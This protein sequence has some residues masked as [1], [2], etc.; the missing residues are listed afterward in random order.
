MRLLIVFLF[1]LSCLVA[2]AQH[3][4]DDLKYLKQ[5]PPALTPTVFAPGLISMSDEYEFGSVFNKDA[6]AF[7][8]AV[9]AEGGAEIRYSALRDDKWSEPVTI[10]SH[11]A[12]GFND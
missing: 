3:V 7:Y 10:L 6:T 8:Y 12:Y 11:A 4:G 2:C 5:Q 9:E 1:S